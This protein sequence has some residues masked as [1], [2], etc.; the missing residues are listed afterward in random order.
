MSARIQLPASPGSVAVARRWVTDQ[1]EPDLGAEF[2]AT[3]GLLVSELVTNVVLHARTRCELVLSRADG[4]LRVEVRD[5][6]PRL[7]APAF[8]RDPTAQSGRGM[9]LVDSISAAH[10][11]EA[12]ADGG[13]VVW[14]ELDLPDGQGGT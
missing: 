13:K 14:F 8:Q 9:Q 1:V 11:A 4:R 10:G 2:S 6:S 3:V 12:S 5:D 7:P